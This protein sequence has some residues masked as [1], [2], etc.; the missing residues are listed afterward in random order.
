MTKT[1]RGDRRSAREHLLEVRGQINLLLKD[2]E[3][4]KQKLLEL[5][6]EE[7]ALHL[8]AVDEAYAQHQHKTKRVVYKHQ[9]DPQ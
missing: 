1:S 7:I 3:A 9:E 8:E 4:N 5:R 2:K 6:E